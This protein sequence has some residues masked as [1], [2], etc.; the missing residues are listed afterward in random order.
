MIADGT[1]KPGDLTP[2]ATALADLTG[3][4]RATCRKA[5]LLMAEH[6]ELVPPLSR[7][8]RPRVPGGDSPG[9]AALALAAALAVARETA[10]L[11]QAQLAERAGLSVS[12]VH[13]AETGLF[14]RPTPQEWARLDRATSADGKLVEAFAAWQASMTR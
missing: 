7:G 12:V 8:G 11:T 3:A 6:G 13:Y 5:V 1:L 14:R 10:G 9:P 2:A 4:A